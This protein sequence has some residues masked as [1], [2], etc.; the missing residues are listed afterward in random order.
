MPC[1]ATSDE[2]SERFPKRLPKA[3]AHLPICPFTIAA[4]SR[5]P[6]HPLLFQIFHPIGK[7][8]HPAR[9]SLSKPKNARKRTFF[10]LIPLLHI[11]IIGIIGNGPKCDAPAV[12]VHFESVGVACRVPSLPQQAACS[13]RLP[14]GGYPPGLALDRGDKPGFC[15]PKT[16]ARVAHVSLRKHATALRRKNPVCFRSCNSRT[17]RCDLNCPVRSLVL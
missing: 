17:N 16:V 10:P 12:E 1:D 6:V 11:R 8:E 7:R 3:T 15:L 13:G 9:N 2:K 4:S 5:D 14:P